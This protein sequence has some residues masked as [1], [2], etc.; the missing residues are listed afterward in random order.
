MDTSDAILL[1]ELRALGR[2]DRM[3]LLRGCSGFPG[4]QAAARTT[5]TGV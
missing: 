1:A 3:L 4:A 2:A 5:A